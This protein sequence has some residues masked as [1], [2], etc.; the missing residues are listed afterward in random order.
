MDGTH[1]LALEGNTPVSLSLATGSSIAGVAGIVWLTQEG[2]AQDVVLG[3]G[4][5]FHVVQHGTIVLNALEVPGRVRVTNIHARARCLRRR[6]LSRL[7]HS[8]ARRITRFARTFGSTATTA[9]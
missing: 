7:A 1:V 6:E 9:K 2:V 8:L 3:A 5:E 4:Q